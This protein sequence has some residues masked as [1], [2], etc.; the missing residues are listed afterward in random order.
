MADDSDNALLSGGYPRS[1][2]VYVNPAA[3]MGRGMAIAGKAYDLREKQAQEAWGQILQQSTDENG[4]VDYPKAQALAAKTPM[5]TMGMMSALKD[6][7]G[8]RSSQF[9]LNTAQNNSVNAAV[10]AALAESD[11]ERMKQTVYEQ[12]QR[13]VQMGLIPLDRAMTALHNMSTDPAEM[14]RQLEAIRLQTLPAQQFQDWTYG[15]RQTTTAGDA[16]YDYTRPRPGGPGV[17]VQHGP[18]P[19]QTTTVSVPVDDQGLIPQDANG[20]PARTPKSWR[21]VTVP[22]TAVPGVSGSTPPAIIPGSGRYTPPPPA[23][24]GPGA[25]AAPAATPAPASAPA[26]P[27]GAPGGYTGGGFGNVLAPAAPGPQ[28]MNLPPGASPALAAIE[29]GRLQAATG[30]PASAMPMV[31]GPG[32]GP[33]AQPLRP[34]DPGWGTGTTGVM[35]PAGDPSAV[36]PPP[37]LGAPATARP[38]VAPAPAARPPAFT[39]PPQGQP[40]KL[41][42]DVEIYA[43]DQKVYPDL[44]TRAQNMAHA[45]DA[46]SMLNSNTG[47]GAAG[48]QN[49]RSYAQTLGLA[50]ASMMKEQELIEVINKYT[51][52]AM[53]DAAGG[54]GTDMARR[55]QEQANP[56]TTLS[57]SA[58]FELLRN[59]MG[60]AMQSAAAYKDFTTKNPQSDGG[61]YPARRAEIADTT[62][63][64]GFVWNL[65][66]DDEKA[67]ILADVKD[68]PVADK[69]LHVAIGMAQLLKLQ[70]P[71]TKPLAPPPQQRSLVTPP[72]SPP[73]ALMMTG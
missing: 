42:G 40:E 30:T 3:S 9:N 72:A 62:D 23:L 50:N 24:V 8:L 22:I 49:L 38:A 43:A 15:T 67:R 7:S 37:A 28:S 51:E 61:G 55:M 58:N 65:Y 66:R 35:P 18:I 1:A 16:T 73:N 26:A 33:T 20:V 21:T 44:Q 53:I 31:A 34:V 2:P 39:G 71:G 5:A 56:G 70:I 4:N 10:T 59:D 57:N 45:Y 52:R 68:N 17:V 29:A 6:T 12:I 64:R 32:A 63:P 47:K 25:G 60:K 13:Q 14:R 69:K 46:L 27:G 48:L 41:K 11:P 19:G 36:P 54:S